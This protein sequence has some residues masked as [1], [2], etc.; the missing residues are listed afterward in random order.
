[1]ISTSIYWFITHLLYRGIRYQKKREMIEK[2]GHLGWEL[3]RK[4]GRA[5]DCA[6][7]RLSGAMCE[8]DIRSLHFAE[9]LTSGGP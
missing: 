1:M 7:V 6:I 5:G 4:K 2:V 8:R 9:I 3:E